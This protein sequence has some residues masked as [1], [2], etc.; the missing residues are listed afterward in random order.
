MEWTVRLDIVRMNRSPRL[1][2]IRGLG[3]GRGVHRRRA[4]EKAR[5]GAMV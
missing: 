1:K 4:M 5:A 2:L 3:M